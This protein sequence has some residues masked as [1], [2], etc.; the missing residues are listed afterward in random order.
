MINLARWY[1]I[2][3]NIALHGTNQR[4]IQRISLMEKFA[5]RPLSEY[6]IEELESLWQNAKANLKRSS[7]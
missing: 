3:P 1:N 5:S 6:N 4:F 7:I 2:E